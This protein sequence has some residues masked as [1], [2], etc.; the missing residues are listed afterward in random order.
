M[1]NPSD[2][3][4]RFATTST[5]TEEQRGRLWVCGGVCVYSV[6]IVSVDV[7]HVPMYCVLPVYICVCVYMCVCVCLM[8]ICVAMDVRVC[9]YAMRIHVSP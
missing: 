3:V 7:V 2:V 9:V 1:E 8:W 5:Y 6:H 4:R